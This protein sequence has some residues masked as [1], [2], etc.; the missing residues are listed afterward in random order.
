MNDPDKFAL[1]PRP[2]NAVGK[3][4]VGAKRIL[5]GMI[6]D[7]LALVPERVNAEIEGWVEKGTSCFTPGNYAKALKWYRKAAERNHGMAQFIVGICYVHGWGAEE[8]EAEGAK[9]FHKSA[10]LGYAE[11][12]RNLGD[13]YQGKQDYISAIK[14][15]RNCLLY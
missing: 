3:T 13:F 5:S 6:A 9:W 15:Y 11:A 4:A 12:Q 1:V 10:E 8:D 2:S 14:W 7:T